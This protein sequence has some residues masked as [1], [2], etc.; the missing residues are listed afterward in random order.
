[1]K[2]QALLVGGAFEGKM[3]TVRGDKE[4]PLEIRTASGRGPAWGS[5]EPGAT[6][7]TSFYRLMSVGEIGRLKVAGYE[8]THTLE[9]KATLVE[10]WLE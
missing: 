6:V 4:A 10:Y 2:I 8:W 3:F 9:A 1:M 7:D 5:K